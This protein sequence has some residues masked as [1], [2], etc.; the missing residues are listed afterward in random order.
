MG[1]LGKALPDVGG[2]TGRIEP[3][4]EAELGGQQAGHNRRAGGQLGI[5]CE[6]ILDPGGLPGTQAEPQVG[7][8]QLHQHRR[9]LGSRAGG[10]DFVDARGPTRH[11]ALEAAQQ[12]LRLCRELPRHRQQ[13]GRERRGRRISRPGRIARRRAIRDPAMHSEHGLNLPDRP[14]DSRCT[15]RGC[16]VNRK[17]ASRVA[18]NGSCA[19]KSGP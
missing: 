1:I 9:A 11:Q 15:H 4:A 19:T 18:N 6:V 17:G 3:A 12:L 13:G 2:V 5:A 7:V 8:D 16:Q 14:R 10:Q